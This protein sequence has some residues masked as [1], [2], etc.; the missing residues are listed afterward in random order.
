MTRSTDC[1]FLKVIFLFLT[2]LTANTNAAAHDTA[3]DKTEFTAQR[4]TLGERLLAPIRWIGRNWN[5]YDPKYS[6]P[7]FYYWAGQMQYTTTFERLSMRTPGGTDIVLDSDVGNRIGPSFGYCGLFYG[8]TIDLNGVGRHSRRRNELT[9]SL[10]SHLMNIDL[11]RRRTG[12]DFNISRLVGDD[13]DGGRTDLTEAANGYGRGEYVNNSLTGINVNVFT[14]HRKYSNPAAFS[15]GSIQIRSAGSPVVGLGFTHQKVETNLADVLGALNAGEDAEEFPTVTRVSDWHLQLGYAYNVAFSRRLLLGLYATVAPSLKHVSAEAAKGNGYDATHMSL[16]LFARSS[17][18]YNYN[19]WRAGLNVS[20]SHYFYDHGGMRV[21]ND[22]G[23][24]ALYASYRFGRRPEYRYNGAMRR[25][26]VCA[27]LSRRQMEEMLDTMPQGNIATGGGAGGQEVLAN[28]ENGKK[29]RTRKYH[30]DC[31]RINV[32]GCD[33]VKGP[34][35][36]YGWYEIEDGYVTPGEDSEGRVTAGTVLELDGNGTFCCELGHNSSIRAG[37][38]WKSQLDIGQVPNYWYPELLHY[39]L[40]GR[41]TLYLRGS[42]FGTKGAVRLDLDDFCINHGKETRSFAQVGIESFRSNSGYSIEGKAEVNGRECRIYIE[43]TE[44]GRHTNMY[45]SRLYGSNAEWM[46]RIEGSRPIGFVCIPGTHDSGTATMTEF[47]PAI[48]HAGH[49]QNF[50]PSAQPYDGIRAFDIRLKDD[51]RY[52]HRFPCRETF[53]STLLAWSRFL[54]EHPTEVLVAIVG[55]DEGDRWDGELGERFS[56]LVSRYS[57]LLCE[58]FSP[59]TPLDSVRGKI[60]IIR[61][62]Q[63]CPFG[64]LLSFTDNAV[65]RYDCFHVEDVYKEHKTYRKARLVERHLREAYENEDPGIW[66]LTF[67]SIAWSPRRHTPYSY[68]WG[69]KA[70]NIRRPLN[71][72]LNETIELKDYT[73]FGI[74]FLDFYNDH[75]EHTKLVET[76]IRANYRL[77]GE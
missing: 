11:I 23:S 38:W 60:L 3:H 27:A 14:N 39:A 31:F 6:L 34:E 40:C 61:R 47:P 68:A 20:F 32:F 65:F 56:S 54:E 25:E 76:I 13:G 44:R 75:G 77:A 8:F 66:Y 55:S 35:G 37:N 70:R 29:R 18:T 15:H 12:G 28:G 59:S 52:G 50:S 5:A 10:N 73:D 46:G 67:N 64:R 41:L 2:L 36:R 63:E 26:Y 30:R 43:Q 51:L 57:H 7:S 71:K 16:N 62:Q 24:V 17:L 1:S 69:G 48:F 33:L 74:V 49:T 53:D 72:T 42:I 21:G 58:D 19:R 45:V 22:Y 9:V 4:K